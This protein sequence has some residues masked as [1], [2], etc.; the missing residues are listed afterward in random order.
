MFLLLILQLGVQICYVVRD[1]RKAVVKDETMLYIPRFRP[2][3]V[4]SAG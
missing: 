4:S 2:A 3:V 1:D